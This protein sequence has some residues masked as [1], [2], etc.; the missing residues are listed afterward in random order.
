MVKVKCRANEHVCFHSVKCEV[1]RGK[2]SRKEQ[3]NDVPSQINKKLPKTT[4]CRLFI[5]GSYFSFLL[6]VSTFYSLNILYTC[7]GCISRCLF[8][9]LLVDSMDVCVSAHVPWK[10]NKFDIKQSVYDTRSEPRRRWRIGIH[11][12][13]NKKILVNVFKCI[14]GRRL[15]RC[16]WRRW[17]RQRRR[18][19]WIVTN[20]C[21]KRK[22]D[23]FT[24]SGWYEHKTILKNIYFYLW[25]QANIS[26]GP[27]PFVSL[28]FAVC[29][30]TQTHTWFVLVEEFKFFP[31]H[32][33][34]DVRLICK[35]MNRTHSPNEVFAAVLPFTS[36]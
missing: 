25:M 3:A 12:N 26:F 33:S 29:A 15:C 35:K 30:H 4:M 14:V 11:E 16:C 13:G 34:N 36:S 8:Y 21:R 23:I 1:N 19:R 17:Q 9:C 22:Y 27:F 28:L 31:W 10:C 2:K 24:I 7:V 20:A 5:V 32:T 18:R 6:F